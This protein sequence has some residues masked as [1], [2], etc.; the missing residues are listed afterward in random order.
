MSSKQTSLTDTV[1]CIDLTGDETACS[2]NTTAPGIREG[3]TVQ[4]KEEDE[5]GKLSLLTWN[6]D[7][8][9][10]VNLGERARGLCSYLVL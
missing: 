7:G 9:D 4:G 1:D 5:A 3:P 6:V 10:T 8:L 2:S